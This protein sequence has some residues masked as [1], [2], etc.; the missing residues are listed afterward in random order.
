MKAPLGLLL[1]VALLTG[2]AA[3]KPQDEAPATVPPVSPTAS[4]RP[5]KIT[6]EPPIDA[7][8]QV[9]ADGRVR[10]TGTCIELVTAT[11]NWVLLGPAAAQLRDGQQVRATGVPDPNR[12]TGCTGSPLL[13]SSV[14]PV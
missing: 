5:P 2:C 11:L 7:F 4:T 14:A 10:I 9:V 13:V 1:A 8:A 3:E 6:S 12:E